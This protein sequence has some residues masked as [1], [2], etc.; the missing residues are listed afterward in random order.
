MK[1]LT[2]TPW[3]PSEK[4]LMAG[5]FVQNFVTETTRLGAEH[6]VFSG[7]GFMDVLRGALHYSKKKNRPD[8]IHLH[9]VTKQGL[10]ALIFRRFYG[11]PYMITEHCSRYYPENGSFNKLTKRPL[12][13][14]MNKW[15]VKKVFE[16]ADKV[17]AVSKQFIEILKQAGLVVNGEV[18][19]N[20]VSECFLPEQ[21]D[22]SHDSS[23]RFVNVTC[24]DN[25]AKNLTGIIDAIRLLKDQKFVFTFIGDG[26]DKKM[27]MEYA[28]KQGVDDKIIFTGEL[29][30]AEVAKMMNSADCL[31]MNSNYETACVVLQEALSLGLPII[32][33]PVGIAPEYTEH[34]EL[35]DANNPD[36]VA[37]VMKRFIDKPKSRY[38][39]VED[40]KNSPKKL[41]SMYEALLSCR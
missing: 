34:I 25:K 18:L 23:P 5:L 11:I 17:T 16:R 28:H 24:F 26:K 19:Y 37:E 36:M 12:I 13:G 30:P 35:V 8:I 7:I 15:F 2:I 41:Y 6:V 38:K 1:V 4:D 20:I 9:V 40:F 14:G 33:T 22:K 21:C 39:G 32:S 29:E 3:Y 27:V 10:I 31:V